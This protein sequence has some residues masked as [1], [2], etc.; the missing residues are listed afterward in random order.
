MIDGRRER[1]CN[2]GAWCVLPEHRF[3][4]LR[5]L[6]AVLAQEGYHFTDL[7]PSGNVVGVN[8]RLGFRFLDT[9][10]VLVP[11]VPLPSWP[12]R[13][14]ISADPAVI[15][16]TLE[17]YALTLYR[18]H[19]TTAAARHLVLIRDD[20]WCYIVF[21]KDRR[22]RVRAFASILYASNPDLLRRMAGPLGR[23][24]LVHH[25]VLAMILEQRILAR[26]PRLAVPLKSRRRKMFRSPRLGAAQID[27]LYSELVCVSW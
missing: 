9:T 2:L 17:G 11:T 13:D 20:E 19:A 12:R 26:P 16:R 22:R 6:R 27:Y 24:L 8:E 5:L 10:A 7:S 3:N 1:F 18:D 23:Y 15:E 25:G 21:R 4:S 14:V